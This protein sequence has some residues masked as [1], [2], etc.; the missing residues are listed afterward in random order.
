MAVKKDNP[1]F[2]RLQPAIEACTPLRVTVTVKK[3][4]EKYYVYFDGTETYSTSEEWDRYWIS[5]EHYVK[6]LLVT[7]GF[8]K[9]DIKITKPK[10]AVA[11][12]GTLFDFLSKD[13]SK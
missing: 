6:H 2:E 10:Y 13:H 8:D 5:F 3:I 1:L 9:I 11:M 7:S 4:K 12:V